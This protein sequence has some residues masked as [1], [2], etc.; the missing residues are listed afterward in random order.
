MEKYWFSGYT[1]EGIEKFFIGKVG[2]Q[3]KNKVRMIPPHTIFLDKG[4][5]AAREIANKARTLAT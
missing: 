3:T 2:K 5:G 4:A 1:A